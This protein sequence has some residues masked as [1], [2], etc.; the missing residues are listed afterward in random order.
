MGETGFLALS[1]H[2]FPNFP[3]TLIA[4]QHPNYF[5]TALDTVPWDHGTGGDKCFAV[6]YRMQF[7]EPDMLKILS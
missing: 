3:S 6:G 2:L 1:H 4:H 5:S 7:L